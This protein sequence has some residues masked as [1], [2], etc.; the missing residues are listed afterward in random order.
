MKWFST[1][2]IT[3]HGWLPYMHPRRINKN[4][5]LRYYVSSPSPVAS[6]ALFGEQLWGVQHVIL[7]LLHRCCSGAAPGAP[8]FPWAHRA[9]CG[10]A[11]LRVYLNLPQ[12]TEH[13]PPCSTSGSP[14]SSS[15]DWI[16][17]KSASPS[18]EGSGST[19]SAI[20]DLEAVLHGGHGQ[21]KAK[22]RAA[23]R[24]FE[25]WAQT[26]HKHEHQVP[27][28]QGDCKSCIK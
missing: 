22:D 21:D 1:S 7:L 18:P 2:W 14:C 6:R 17:H 10:L 13:R 12:T 5:S 24:L 27:P 26:Q 25:P 28:R 20:V 11:E 23:L 15:R 8:H 9:F 4:I 16:W 3:L 19:S